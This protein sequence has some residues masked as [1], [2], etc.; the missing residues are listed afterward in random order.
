MDNFRQQRNRFG[1]LSE[2]YTKFRRGYPSEVFNII[3]SKLKNNNTALDVGC[4]TGI[5]TKEIAKFCE[6]VIGTDKEEEMLAQARAYAPECEFINSPAENLPFEDS[7]FDLLIVAQAFHWFDYEKAITEFKRVTNSD[8]LI[9]I[10][11]KSSKNGEK[12]LPQFVWEALSQYTKLTEDLKRQDGFSFLKSSGFKSCELVELDYQDTYTPDEYIGF[13]KTHSTF[14][15]VPDNLKE[16]YLQT[17]KEKIQNYLQDGLYTFH[18][19]IEIW[20]LQK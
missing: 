8:G 20:L 14:N 16:E 2:D 6:S 17:I 11:R 13:L 10:F 19:L 12:I 5:A 9:A 4:G 1:L 15:L 3:K 18:G 7:H